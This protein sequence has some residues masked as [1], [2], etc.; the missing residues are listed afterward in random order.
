[1]CA[2]TRARARV[3]SAAAIFAPKGRR[4]VA[5]GEARASRAQPVEGCVHSLAC[6]GGA[7]EAL[8]AP[9]TRAPRFLPPPLPG[10]FHIDPAFHGFRCA[11]PVATSRRPA[12]AC[13]GRA[14]RPNWARPR[15]RAE[16]A[17]AL[18]A[19]KGRR[20]VATGE[21]RASR[22]QPVEG[23]PHAR[24]CPGGAEEIHSPGSALG[25]RVRPFTGAVS[26][27]MSFWYR[28]KRYSTRCRSLVNGAA[29]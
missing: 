11:P 12:G 25:A 14:Y 4:A 2:L 8:C 9:S 22:A 24:D 17:A 26:G 5:T 29:R 19:P 28:S 21:A 16:W 7:E 18:F 1:M 10:R 6:P 27:V 23:E 13:R 15:A 20:A 3:E